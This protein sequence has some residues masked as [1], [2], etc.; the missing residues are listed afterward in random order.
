[1][2]SAA[3]DPTVTMWEFLNA[4]RWIMLGKAPS[5]RCEFV[6]SLQRMPKYEMMLPQIVEMA[7]A[8]SGVDLISRALGIGA[9]VVRLRLRQ[10]R[11]SHRSRTGGSRA[12]TSALQVDLRIPGRKRDSG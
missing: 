6:I 8:G 1:M 10:S 12:D 2:A 3:D 11:R 4:D 9:E 7:E 5:G